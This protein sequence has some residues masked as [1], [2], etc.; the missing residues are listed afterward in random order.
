MRQMLHF[1]L[2]S[3]LI[4]SDVFFHVFDV[5][6]IDAPTQCTLL[7][8]GGTFQHW[9]SYLFFHA[10]LKVKQPGYI[11]RIASGKLAVYSECRDKG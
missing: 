9:Q 3:L 2:S 10:A 4:V 8:T 5:Y 7:Q 6:I 1:I 11:T